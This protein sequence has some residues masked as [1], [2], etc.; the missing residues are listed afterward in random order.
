[1]DSNRKIRNQYIIKNILRRSKE[2]YLVVSKDDEGN[3]CLD[4]LSSLIGTTIK[5]DNKEILIQ[6]R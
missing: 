6:E 5:L 4:T 2:E 1:M 3:T